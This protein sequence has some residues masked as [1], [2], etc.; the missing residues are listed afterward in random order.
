M[1]SPVPDVLMKP[2]AIATDQL[3]QVWQ[4]RQPKAGPIAVGPLIRAFVKDQ[5]LD[6]PSPLAALR[7]IWGELVGVELSR[8]SRLE[9]F[10]R[11]S[12][13]V[14]VDSAAHMSELQTLVRSGLT[15]RIAERFDQRPISSIRLRLGHHTD[16]KVTRGG[17][18]LKGKGS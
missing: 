14:V 17:R 3:Q 1:E 10:R 9:G 13:R 12:L 15:E 4:N 6:H 8:H 2:R 5:G 18:K 11:G 7:S 16:Q